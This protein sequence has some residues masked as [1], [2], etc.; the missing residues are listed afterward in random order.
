MKRED[1]HR[2]NPGGFLSEWFPEQTK[3]PLRIVLWMIVYILDVVLVFWLAGKLGFDILSVSTYQLR[4]V[5]LGLYLV[6]ALCI[7]RV[8]AF[9]YNKLHALFR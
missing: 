1:Y 9:I 8:E 5:V 3:S 2:Y 6:I 4:S 7:F